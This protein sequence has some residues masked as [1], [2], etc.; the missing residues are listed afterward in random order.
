MNT[1]VR[2]S[3]AKINLTLRIVGRRPDGYHDIESLVARISLYDTISVRPRDDGRRTVE[4]S[5]PTIPADERNLALQAASRLAEVAGRREGVHIAI[6]KRIPAGAGLGGGSSNAATVLRLLNDL[7]RLGVSP[8]ELARIGAQLGSD[9]PLFFHGPVCIL[10][11]RGEEIEEVAQRLATAVTLLL[12]ALQCS[13]RAVYDAWDGMP[14]QPTGPPLN[15]ILQRLGRPVDL[16]PLLFNELEAP[17]RAAYP[18]LAAF[19]AG[20]AACSPSPVRMTGSG[21]G[22]FCLGDMGGQAAAIAAQVSRETGMAV[23]VVTAETEV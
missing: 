20:L 3:P 9:V 8:V 23:R 15:E 13:T 17:A 16:A 18:E 2:R 5:D 22:F 1:L 11:G 19:A 6:D 12:P 21:A 4:C 14:F 7:W 10:R